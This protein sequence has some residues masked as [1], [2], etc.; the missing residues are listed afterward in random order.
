MSA[1]TVLVVDD[2]PQI[3]RGLRVVLRTAG[4]EV[5]SAATKSEALD[6]LAVRPPDI[7]V[8][9]LVLPDGSGVDVCQEVRRWSA[10]PIIVLSAVGDEHEKVR[11]LDAGADD[12][13]TKPFGADELTARLRALLRR[14]SDTTES[15]VVELG[16]LTIDLA[17]RTVMRD[18]ERVH[19]TPI[20]YDLLAV[21]TKHRGKL[22]THR[23]LLQQVWGPQYV[24]ETHYLRV[25]VAHM[26]QKL[27]RDPSRPQHIVT[28][29][30]VG[31]RLLEASP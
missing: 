15:P 3:V 11:A 31:Y 28:D 26:R 6:A 22:V 30:G 18:G 9:D 17:S 23:Q 10:L 29:P 25:H 27:E 12:Y 7:M 19:L 4:F 2:E 5:H 20:E 14:A 1:A 13:I 8:L 16:D 24:D 21:L